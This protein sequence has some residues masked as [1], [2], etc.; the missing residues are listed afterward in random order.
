MTV[1]L[2][3]PPVYA[4]QISEATGTSAA[5]R[6]DRTSRSPGAGVMF[7]PGREQGGAGMRREERERGW[8]GM[9]VP[10]EGKEA[11]SLLLLSPR[12]EALGIIG[13][14]FSERNEG[15]GKEK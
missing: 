11:A 3:S 2:S 1:S 8:R 15:R 10:E 9:R 5:A 12:A 7:L 13:G 6:Q 14:E 4:E